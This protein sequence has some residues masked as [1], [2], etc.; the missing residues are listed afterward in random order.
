MHLKLCTAVCIYECLPTHALVSRPNRLYITRCTILMFDFQNFTVAY[1]IMYY[2]CNN[3][4]Y[5]TEMFK[6]IPRD[7]HLNH[8]QFVMLNRGVCMQK[9]EK[10]DR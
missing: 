2:V 7:K 5:S 3:N 4:I 9:S 6:L 10:S 1:N 8:L